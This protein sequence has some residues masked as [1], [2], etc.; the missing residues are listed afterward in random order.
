MVSQCFLKVGN[1]RQFLRHIGDIIRPADIAAETDDAVLLK[2]YNLAVRIILNCTSNILRF[3][4]L[5]STFLKRGQCAGDV[6][7]LWCLRKYCNYPFVYKRINDHNKRRSPWSRRLY[8]HSFC[9]FKWYEIC[10][11]K[12]T[13]MGAKAVKLLVKGLYKWWANE[14]CK[15]KESMVMV[16]LQDLCL[17]KTGHWWYICQGSQARWYFEDLVQGVDCY[18]LFVS[19]SYCQRWALPVKS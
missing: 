17:S 14:D 19:N 1:A 12:I 4:C 10:Q 2:K 18:I 15:D 6:T 7:M 13:E 8:R 5:W 16:L 11:W 9:H 3:V